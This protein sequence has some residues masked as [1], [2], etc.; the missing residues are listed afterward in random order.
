[1]AVMPSDD[2]FTNVTKAGNDSI[3]MGPAR[4]FSVCRQTF[5]YPV[6]EELP[7]IRPESARNDTGATSQ[8]RTYPFYTIHNCVYDCYNRQMGPGPS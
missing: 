1:M 8:N 3:K 4:S 5:P 2:I 6:T 7:V